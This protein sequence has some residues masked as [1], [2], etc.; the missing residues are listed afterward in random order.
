MPEPEVVPAAPADAVADEPTPS[1]TLL[2]D[3]PPTPG[4]EAPA[5]QGG[6]EQPKGDAQTQD[7]PA[8]AKPEGVP[9][10]YEFALPEGVVMDEGLKSAFEPVAKELNLSNEAA[11]KLVDLYAN[12][13]KTVREAET[14]Q[15]LDQVKK[16]DSDFRS[17]KEYG[18][19]NL[20]ASLSA[21]KVVMSKFGSPELASFLD[22]SGLGNHPELVRF[23]VRI[24]RSM[25]PDAFH[26]GGASTPARSAEEVLYPT[27]HTQ[28]E[29]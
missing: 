6:E 24:G 18:G 9:E 4:G 8:D 10:K 2:G 19:E 13:T 26:R 7:K 20:N 12:H 16:W 28:P 27:M 15:W 11:Q 17:D 5:H 21:L 1:G 29:K 22:A 14:K 23:C 3:P 25:A